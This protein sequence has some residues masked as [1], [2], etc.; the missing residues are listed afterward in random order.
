MLPATTDRQ[1]RLFDALRELERRFGPDVVYRLSQARPK[2]GERSVSSGSIGIDHITGIGGFPRG[3]P[4]TIDGPESSGKTTLAY[5]LIAN[6]QRDS[7]MAALIDVEQVVD[8]ALLVS[9]GANLDDLVLGMPAD[10]LEALEQADILA[11]SATLD[12]IVVL[13]LGGY[14]QH[15]VVSDASRRIA[16]SI[17]VTPTALAYVG[18]GQRIPPATLHASLSLALRPVGLLARQGGEVIGMTVR[19]EV[20]ASRLGPPGLVATIDIIDGRGISRAAELLRL[21]VQSEVIAQTSQGL[22]FAD[23]LLG[24]GRSSALERIGLDDALARSLEAAVRASL[25]A[26][27]I[28]RPAPSAR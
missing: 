8:P 21:G 1:S 11:R 4:A 28:P 27:I 7:G 14:V 24:R 18:F 10:P 26:A 23:V 15:R 3:R 25:D 16:L 19:T 6:A 17:A 5:H 20:T 2:L 22:I 9:V 13:G 12:A